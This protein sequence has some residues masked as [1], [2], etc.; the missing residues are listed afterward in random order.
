M[1][2]QMTV[3]PTI[4]SDSKLRAIVANATEVLEESIGKSWSSSEA[5]VRWDSA[6]DDTDRDVVVLTLDD[7]AGE[8]R[9]IF[10]MEEMASPERLRRRFNWLYGDLLQGRSHKQIEKLMSPA[11]SGDNE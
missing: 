6:K 2:R 3:S 9:G 1:F 7:W 11:R 8:V 4:E 5:G 10:T